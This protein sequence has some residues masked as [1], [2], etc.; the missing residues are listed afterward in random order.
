M[1]QYTFMQNAFVVS[2]FIALLC[3]FIGIFLVLRRYSMIGDTLSHSSLAGIAGGLLLD[4]NPILSAFVF[5]S[6]CGALIEFLRVYFKKYTDLIL[7]IVLSLSVGTAI[8]IISSGAI[9]ADVNSFMF[10][11]ILTVTT[12]DLITV[13]CLSV[14]SVITLFALYNQLVFIAFDEEAAKIAG[15][16]VKI[17]NYIFSVL[18]AATISVSIRIVGVLVLSS[19]I[20]LPVAA[21]LQLKKGFKI[22]LAASVIVSVIDIMSGLVISFY[23]GCAPGGMTALISVFMLCIVMAAQK[24]RSEMAKHRSRA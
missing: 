24:V 9:N 4:I 3:P 11:S 23:A 12:S 22:T 15:V 10:G 14:I 1:L 8:T 13:I 21:A 5:T 2:L 7:T 18:V 17:I 20:A 16:K 19:M 6:L